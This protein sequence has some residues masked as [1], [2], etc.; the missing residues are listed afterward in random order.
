MMIMMR[1]M[2]AVWR[3]CSDDLSTLS[4]YVRVGTAGM[5]SLRTDVFT[6]RLYDTDTETHISSDVDLFCSTFYSRKTPDTKFTITEVRDDS[7]SV[8]VLRLL[9]KSVKYRTL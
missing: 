6:L 3:S 5:V 7:H 2:A 1:I 4:V 9:I 8:G